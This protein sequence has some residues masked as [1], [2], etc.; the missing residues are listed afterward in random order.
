MKLVIIESPYM[1]N[2]AF[3]VTTEMHVEY[4]RQCV[5]NSLS[6]GEA[7]IA[8]HLLYTQPG[9]LDDALPAEREHGIAAGLAWQWA[10]S[11][12][13]VYKD[14]GISS[15][16]ARG[17]EEAGKNRIRVEYRSLPDVYEVIIENQLPYQLKSV[18]PVGL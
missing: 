9:I 6:L 7:P 16:M 18:D 8:S 5:A 11:L 15:G 12:V 4:A 17:I 1:G 3:G 14:F 10:A 13:A 2:P